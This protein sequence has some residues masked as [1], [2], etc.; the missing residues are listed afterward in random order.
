M[1]P[2][3]KL[4]IDWNGLTV[5]PTREMMFDVVKKHPGITLDGIHNLGYRLVYSALHEL[6]LDEIIFT[7]NQRY[8]PNN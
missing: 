3:M 2:D 6:I 8:Y 4:P 5:G 1:K 7:E